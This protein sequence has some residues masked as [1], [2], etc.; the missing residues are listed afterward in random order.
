MA[1]EKTE[2]SE[3]N[4][5]QST[6][7]SLINSIKK[8]REISAA[9]TT[10]AEKLEKLNAAKANTEQKITI[11]A[12]STEDST[13]DTT[14]INIQTKKALIEYNSALQTVDTKLEELKE[15]YD[16]P[17]FEKG[18]RPDQTEI[19]I[20]QDDISRRI[21]SFQG[22]LIEELATAPTST[23]TEIVQNLPLLIKLRESLQDATANEG[24][25]AHTLIQQL[26]GSSSSIP[27]ENKPFVNSIIS[28]V[29]GALDKAK[30]FTLADYKQ[31][32][33]TA[34]SN[35]RLDLAE[36]LANQIKNSIDNPEPEEIREL[37]K[38]YKKVIDFENRNPDTSTD[39]I[40]RAL[41]MIIAPSKTIA[42][43]T[44]LEHKITQLQAN[45]QKEGVSMA[46]LQEGKHS[47]KIGEQLK[48]IQALAKTLPKGH[49]EK[50][51]SRTAS[52]AVFFIKH[53]PAAL[54]GAMLKQVSEKTQRHVLLDIAKKYADP[55]AKKGQTTN[56]NQSLSHFEKIVSRV[57]MFSGK[58][59]GKN[60]TD[61]N[62]P[63]SPTGS[64][65][66]R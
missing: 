63:P 52:A 64:P 12:D 53:A 62:E 37:K 28:F 16:S 44:I 4:R 46:A 30:E 29:S 1:S 58:K 18:G 26:L 40:T 13:E 55:A 47:Q 43:T 2:V 57:G 61:T 38:L 17:I 51:L 14:E 10:V 23:L 22:K 5:I 36:V 50:E 32:I 60:N 66:P 25:S 21:Q 41:A 65:G 15:L 48:T 6:L 42:A 56:A 34:L 35:N 24:E 27:E 59:A 49:M 31:S 9:A 11:K 3:K 45:I 20:L 7:D 54:A 33:S 8:Y 39:K 19:K